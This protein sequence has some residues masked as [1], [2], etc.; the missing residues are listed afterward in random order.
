MGG[1]SRIDSFGI[2]PARHRQPFVNAT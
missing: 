1:R 2:N